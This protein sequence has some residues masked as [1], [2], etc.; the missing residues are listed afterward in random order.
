[1]R[2]RRWSVPSASAGFTK[3][4]AAAARSNRPIGS[5]SK[6]PL[7]EG[8][9][10]PDFPR[11]IRCSGGD[12]EER[13]AGA[14]RV[15]DR[16]EKVA[17]DFGRYGVNLVHN[18]HQR[19]GIGLNP[20]LEQIGASVL[21]SALSAVAPSGP[22]WTPVSRPPVRRAR[23]HSERIN[24]P[25]SRSAAGGRSSARSPKS[26]ARAAMCSSSTVLPF[27]PRPVEEQSLRGSGPPASCPSRMSARASSASRPARYG[28][29]CPAPGRK[30]VPAL[31]R[32]G[33]CPPSP[34][35]RAYR[36]ARRCR[37]SAAFL[38]GRCLATE[39]RR[40]RRKHGAPGRGLPR[41]TG[42]PSPSGMRCRSRSTG[43]HAR[44]G[45]CSRRSWGSPSP[46]RP[47]RSPT[48]PPGRAG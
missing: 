27:P 31:H 25:S 28:G 5:R 13:Q 2:S 33:Q 11:R 43:G 44:G 20:G 29:I 12:Q 40:R 8:A 39:T 6:N 4:C 37:G 48:P 21:G 42:G 19:S 10:V 15:L 32:P 36:T 47:R 14:A 35:S 46:R 23:C 26:L 9:G 30:R 16:V 18:D 22:D 45:G 24:W 34:C 7:G 41:G 1:M 3:A 17:A 38:P